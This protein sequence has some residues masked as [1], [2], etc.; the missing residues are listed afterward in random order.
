MLFLLLVKSS[1]GA[2][3][4]SAQCCLFPLLHSSRTSFS[5]PLQEGSMFLLNFITLY[6][7]IIAGGVPKVN[8]PWLHLARVFTSRAPCSSSYSLFRSHKKKSHHFIGLADKKAT[9]SV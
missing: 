2:N 5:N 1:F 4:N 9:I 7:A 8:A 3:K 6:S